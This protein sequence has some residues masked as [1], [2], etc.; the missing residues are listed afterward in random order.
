M[1]L[2]IYGRDKDNVQI[3]EGNIVVF[4]PIARESG[5]KDENSKDKKLKSY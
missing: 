2:E 4:Y 3:Q 1:V 5:W